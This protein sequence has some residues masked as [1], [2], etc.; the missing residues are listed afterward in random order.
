MNLSGILHL[1]HPDIERM[2]REMKDSPLL[3]RLLGKLHIIEK[4]KNILELM[5]AEE[6]GILSHNSL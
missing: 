1:V 2:H 6:T 3:K 5:V 4:K